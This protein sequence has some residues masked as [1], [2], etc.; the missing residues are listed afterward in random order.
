MSLAPVGGRTSGT[1]KPGVFYKRRRIPAPPMDPA[2]RWLKLA[3]AYPALLLGFGAASLYYAYRSRIDFRL[4]GPNANIA[5]PDMVPY[6]RSSA[7]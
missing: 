5:C 1:L 4:C 7:G 2:R 6:P 3:Y